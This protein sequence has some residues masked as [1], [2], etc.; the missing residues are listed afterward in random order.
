MQVTIIVPGGMEYDAEIDEDATA[1]EL[2]EVLTAQ[3]GLPTKDPS[4]TP[5]RYKLALPVSLRLE[6]GGVLEVVQVEPPQRF[7]PFRRE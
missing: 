4:G 5:I 3:L 1:S 6:E 7:L 2:L